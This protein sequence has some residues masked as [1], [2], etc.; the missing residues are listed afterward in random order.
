[1]RNRKENEPVVNDG[2]RNSKTPFLLYKGTVLPESG[3]FFCVCRT[4]A[5]LQ[6]C[7]VI[8]SLREY[9]EIKKC[10]NA[11]YFEKT[12]ATLFLSDDRIDFTER[13]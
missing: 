9:D 11:E 1:M 4:F 10:G 2:F 13:E 5:A 7:F 12:K 6:H 8:F 3:A